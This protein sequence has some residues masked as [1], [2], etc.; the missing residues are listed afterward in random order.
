MTNPPKPEESPFYN[1]DDDTRPIFEDG[2]GWSDDAEEDNTTEADG[3][4][5]DTK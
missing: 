3:H 4:L 5:T 1:E 2:I